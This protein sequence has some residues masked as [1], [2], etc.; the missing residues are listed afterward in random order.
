MASPQ[1]VQEAALLMKILITAVSEG[2]ITAEA[3]SRVLP[4]VGNTY[5]LEDA[6]EGTGPQNRLFHKLVRIFYVSG[7][8]SYPHGTVWELRQHILKD[9]G[10][11]FESFLYVNDNGSLSEVKRADEIPKHI[12]AQREKVRGR[13]IRWSDYTLKERQATIQS[14]IA[15]M[16]EADVSG[17]DF[18][19]ILSEF[20]D[21]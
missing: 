16:L 20:Y 5:S 11:G 21:G 6:S 8:H 7:C 15:Q 19:S 14:L 13:L 9:L 17:A 4:V 18:E 2:K 3:R 12:R 1:T 10:K